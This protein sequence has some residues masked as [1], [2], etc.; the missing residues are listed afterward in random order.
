MASKRYHNIDGSTSE[1]VELLPA[2]SSIDNISSISISN[3][4]NSNNT[5]ISLNLYNDARQ[6][7]FQLLS[8]ITIPVGVTFILDDL[9]LL[10]FNNSRRGFGLF[11]NVSSSTTCDVLINSL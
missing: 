9:A 10:N 2:G 1:Y 8:K 7:T 11:A 3:T 5:S 6:E 4:S